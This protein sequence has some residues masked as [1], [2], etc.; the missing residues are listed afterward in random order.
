MFVTKSGSRRAIGHRIAF[1]T[2]IILAAVSA[3]SASAQDNSDETK[4]STPVLEEVIVTA[5]KFQENLQDT[6][7]S[8]TALTA[9]GLERRQITSTEDLDQATPNLSFSSAA[10][11]AANQAQSVIYIRGIGQLT[12][13]AN[14]DPG[15][16]I[17]ID[18]VYLSQSVGGTM[19]FR[20][21]ESVQVL[22][23]PQ[24]TLFGRN[25]IGGAV[26]ITT[27]D[28]SLTSGFEGT[29]KVGL[30]TDNLRDV[31]VAA[32]IPVSDTFA[33]RAS[34]GSRTRDGYVLRPFDGKKL[35]D[36]DTY[37]LTTKALW[38]PNEN[39]EVKLGFDYTHA[40]E[41]GVAYQNVGISETGAFVRGVSFAAGCPGMTSVG[42]AVPL[43]DD[44]RC[45]NDFLIG[46]EGTNNGTH[47]TVSNLESWGLSLNM[48]YDINENLSLK[49]ITAYRSLD[50]NGNRDPDGTPYPILHTDYSSEGDQ[51]SQELQVLYETERLKAV[52]G[53]Y[54]F[55][56]E[57]TDIVTVTLAPPPFPGGIG[58]SDNNIVKNHNWAVFSQATYD[59]TDA[60]SL[61]VGGRYTADTKGSIPDQF[62]YLAPDDKYLTVR[63]Y[64]KTFKSFTASASAAYRWNDNFMTY[65]SFSQGFK[66]GGWNSNFNTF[67]PKDVLNALHSF[68]E[69]N[70]ETWE[71]GFKADALDNRLRLNGALFTTSYDDLQFTYRYQVAPLLAN[72]GKA[73]IKGLELELSWLLTDRLT[74]D[75][76]FGY[77]D[78][79]I[80]E[81]NDP[82]VGGVTTGV[83]T[84]SSIPFTPEVSANIGLGYES[85][86]FSNGWR[87]LPRV[88]LVY[89]SN[90]F[91][92]AQN[93]PEISQGGSVTLLNASVTFENGDGDWR[94][95]VSGKNL[96]DEVYS[97][98]GNSALS[99]SSGYA[100][101]VLTRGRE[102]FLNLSHD[103]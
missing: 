62:S 71:L 69:E 76:G 12:P 89:T 42:Q 29:F 50:W 47:K 21:I 37:T 30:G 83:T 86:A 94:L 99:V 46:E 68:D 18:D 98:G 67:L 102:F 2:S 9:N 77:L 19:D 41:N 45:V 65:L 34:F 27:R 88:D 70:A 80:K 82:T 93:T 10:P 15:V 40:D 28:P 100:E 55:D 95:Q 73:T 56:E 33:L 25:T 6:P 81:V 7:I 5:R 87:M 63:L 43:I 90:Q 14:V 16:G 52:M 23:G 24:G 84:A 101:A 38:M 4:S 31:F 103:F 60:F 59:V 35:G 32:N 26:V 79:E 13:T 97:I 1:T 44:P 49:S 53:F 85:E 54:Y 92:D 51:F 48:K 57:V 3:N 39:F 75:A 20:D 17:Y 74:L 22:R 91:Y 36:D 72:A 58:D 61:T 96:T 66:G 11:L 64:E 8:V 78:D